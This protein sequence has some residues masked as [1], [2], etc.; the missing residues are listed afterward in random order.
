MR[1]KIYT[2]AGGRQISLFD[3]WEVVKPLVDPQQLLYY[4]ESQEVTPD[5]A[6]G[7]PHSSED[8]CL[9]HSIS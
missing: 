7:I 4:G 9:N 5:A 6:S 8:M 1:E 3:T 2:M